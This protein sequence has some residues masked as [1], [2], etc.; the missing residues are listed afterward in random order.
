MAPELAVLLARLLQRQ[1]YVSEEPADLAAL[2]AA[3]RATVHDCEPIQAYV[4]EGGSSVE[5]YLHLFDTVADATAGRAECADGAYNTSA[6][7]AIP[8]S[9]ALHPQFHEVVESILKSSLDME[10]FD[11]AEQAT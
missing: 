8:R 9:L 7:T 10:C 3:A 6:I 1:G 5:V 2:L 4:Q 11:A